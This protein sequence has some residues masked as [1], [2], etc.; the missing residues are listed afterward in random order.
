M[1]AFAD[2]VQTHADRITQPKPE[3]VIGDQIGK[4][5]VAI[6]AAAASYASLVG[7]RK[8]SSPT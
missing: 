5:T 3:S 6:S 2:A 1:A 4:M 8:D 7:K